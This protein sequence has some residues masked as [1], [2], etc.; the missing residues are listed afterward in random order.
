MERRR[1]DDGVL[2][3]VAASNNVTVLTMSDKS[4]ASVGDLGELHKLVTR[5]YTERIK[6]D[7]EDELPTDAATLAG[8]AKFLKDNSITADP[9]DSDDLGDLRKQLANQA[10]AR[11]KRKAN[12]ASIVALVK[13][14][15]G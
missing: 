1:F 7:L 10:E 14:E 8:A 13:A 12:G 6:T 15:E 3:T 2:T 9:A 4:P 5:A 11:R